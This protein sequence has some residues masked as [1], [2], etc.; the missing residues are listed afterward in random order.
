[1][2]QS[3]RSHDAALLL[4]AGTQEAPGAVRNVKRMG[5]VY[6]DITRWRGKPVSFNR[7]SGVDGR[8]MTVIIGIAMAIVAAGC[9]G[10]YKTCEEM[11]VECQNLGGGCTKGYPGCDVY[12][13]ASCG[14]CLECCLAGIPYP[15]KCKCRRCGFD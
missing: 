13:K 4:F 14:S 3:W 10:S 15:P 8:P 9:G 2:P 1:M 11:Y 5:H 7:D 6:V 12:G